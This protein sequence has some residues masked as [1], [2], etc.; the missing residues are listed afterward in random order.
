[1]RRPQERLHVLHAL[2]TS[3]AAAA[4]LSGPPL[5]ALP[6][7]A[8][9]PDTHQLLAAATEA[10]YD[11]QNTVLAGSTDAYKDAVML[12]A[13]RSRAFQAIASLLHWLHQAPPA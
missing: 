3:P 13:L 8:D 6:T 12:A 1:L 11:L 2:L 7:P 4:L 10:L 9:Q 5:T